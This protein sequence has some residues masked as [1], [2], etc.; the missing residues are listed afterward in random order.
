MDAEDKQPRV[1]KPAASKVRKKR[2]FKYIWRTIPLLLVIATIV[3]LGVLINNK[4]KNDRSN[5]LITN[6]T[7][8]SNK[9]TCSK[10]LNQIS[11]TATVLAGTHYTTSAR[12]RALEYLM[13]CSNITGNNFQAL[14]YA[15]QLE[16]LYVK[17]KNTQK[18]Q[19]I[20]AYISYIK[21]SGQQ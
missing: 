16:A 20:T 4:L 15:N 5:K 21:R 3:V 6:I 1:I 14:D 17:D 9:E 10:G 13:A 18:Q 11:P 7:N 2:I 12:E 19:E 8:L